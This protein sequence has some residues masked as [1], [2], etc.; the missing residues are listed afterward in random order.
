MR[1]L[2][3]P[4]ADCA[5][6]AAVETVAEKIRAAGDLL[7]ADLREPGSNISERINLTLNGFLT[8][9]F[10]AEPGSGC[11]FNSL[12]NFFDPIISCGTE[13]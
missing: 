10:R 1:A 2:H 4:Q 7:I 9:P 6:L 5:K 3:I 12:Y 8:W 13:S 11:P